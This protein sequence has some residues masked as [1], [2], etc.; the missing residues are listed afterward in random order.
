MRRAAARPHAAALLALALLLQA[1]S[2]ARPRHQAAGGA[3]EAAAGAQGGG[4]AAAAAAPPP[5][6]HAPPPPGHAPPP[7]GHAH[8]FVTLLYDDS[9]L[10]GVRALGQSLREAGTARDLVAL[11]AGAASPAAAVALAG[12]GWR[13]RRVGALANP[14]R[15][16]Q[17]GA[18][19]AFPPRFWGVYTKLLV[20]NLT[21]YERVVYMDAD[22]VAA[23]A[24]DE[25]FLCDGVCGVL[26]AAERLNT[27]VL[28][29]EP[30][31]ALLAEMLAAAATTPSY[32]GGDQGFL[33][34]FFGD[35]AAAPLF[36]PA[37]GERLSLAAPGAAGARGVR[38]ARLPTRYNADL[39][40]W[41]ANSGRWA[42][43]EG[44]IAVIHYTLGAIVSSAAPL[45][46]Q[47]KQRRPENQ[48][49]NEPLT[50]YRPHY[51]K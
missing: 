8:A 16:S 32:T 21:E 17:A 35:F 31:A 19:A 15:W 5:P 18:A 47:S 6:G 40:L 33:N 42:L 29:L 30:D 22:T 28:V 1:A 39:G 14:G 45:V 38:L 12:D 3:S 48:P 13:V 7:P 36:D 27:G 2:A 9:F 50:D 34:S 26:R 46:S 24:I 51:P 11:V 25:L 49:T 20:W 43:D 23:R 10:L 41:V 44:S 4:G 37:R